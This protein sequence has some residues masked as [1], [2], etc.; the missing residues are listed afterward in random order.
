MTFAAT[1]RLLRLSTIVP[2]RRS[3]GYDSWHPTAPMSQCELADRAGVDPAYV[4]RLER[5]LQRPP[6]RGVV[7]QLARALDLDERATDRLLVA[8]GYW[9]WQTDDEAALE[10]AI[11]AALGV[12]RSG[13]TMDAR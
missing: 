3:N 9:P 2:V 11:A 8:A 6:T 7:E 13:A 12:L 5:G 10:Y 1:L 4:N